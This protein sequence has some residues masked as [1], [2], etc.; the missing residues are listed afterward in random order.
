M[1]IERIEVVTRVGHGAASAVYLNRTTWVAMVEQP[2]RVGRQMDEIPSWRFLRWF[3]C[4][5]GRSGQVFL[6]DK[7]AHLVKGIA[8]VINNGL[9]FGNREH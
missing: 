8:D 4:W 1:A 9:S 7:Y 2:C 6:D 5:N 3:K